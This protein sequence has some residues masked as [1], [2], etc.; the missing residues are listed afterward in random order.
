M[1][2]ETKTVRKNFRFTPEIVAMA[3]A[4]AKSEGRTVTNY[5]ERLIVMDNSRCTDKQKT[6]Y[7]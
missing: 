2:K 5:I 6:V 1:E 7:S 4:G 3:E